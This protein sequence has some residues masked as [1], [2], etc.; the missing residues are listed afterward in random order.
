PVAFA[1]HARPLNRLR[2]EYGLPG[3]GHDLRRTYTDADHVLYADVPELVPTVDLP[4][5]HHYLGPVLWSPALGPPA[6]W[7]DVPEDRPIVYVT[8][9]SS[10]RPGLL[11]AALAALEGLPVTALAATAGRPPPA[12]VPGNARVADYLPGEQASARASLVVCN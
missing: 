2:R 6:W 11:D 1:V 5:H 7:G 9:G 4:P 3:L 8:L 12:R 10:G